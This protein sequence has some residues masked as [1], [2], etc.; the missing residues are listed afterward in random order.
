M[1]ETSKQLIKET[2]VPRPAQLIGSYDYDLR[3]N[4]VSSLFMLFHRW[5]DGAESRSE[6]SHEG[7][8]AHVIKKLVD[9]DYPDRDRIV[10]G[11]SQHSQARYT[12]HSNLL[13][14]GV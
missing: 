5:T 14:R 12:R 3:A 11:Q 9:E 7:G 1:D 8:W 10:H 6:A 2:R 13:R 4:G